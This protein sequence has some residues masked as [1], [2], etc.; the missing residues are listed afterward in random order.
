MKA[1][2]APVLCASVREFRVSEGFYHRTTACAE[3]QRIVRYNRRTPPEAPAM[4]DKSI[5]EKRLKA[6]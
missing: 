4:A 5:V 1:M 6:V 3:Q 2:P